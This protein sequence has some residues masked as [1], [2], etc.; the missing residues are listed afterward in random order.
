MITETLEMRTIKQTQLKWW[1]GLIFFVAMHFIAAP[2]LQTP[3]YINSQLKAPF[4]PPDWAFAPIWLINTVLMVWAG[5]LL[6]QKPDNAPNRSLL[7]TLQIISW[8]C[9]VTFG[10]F[11]FGL[12]SP[13]IGG[14]ITLFMFGVNLASFLI[15]FNLDKR[16]SYALIP[17]V[18]WLT[19]A[20]AVAL[21]QG[22][23]NPDELLG[24]STPLRFH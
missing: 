23:H 19:V 15:G 24:I 10:W 6:I 14:S 8:I 13:I 17:L 4:A 2:W 7:L 22:F 21:Y 12:H 3:D 5:M 18:I 1:H 11:Y 20:S 16:F 9:F